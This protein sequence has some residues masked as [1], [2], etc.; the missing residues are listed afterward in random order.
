MIVVDTN[1]VAYLLIEG[2]RTEQARTVWAHDAEWIVPSLWRS[3]ML[4]VLATAVRASVLTFDEAELVRERAWD[5]F[6]ARE[7]NPGAP[8]VLRRAVE[9]GISAYDAQF[10]VVAEELDLLLVTGD[11][12]L[13]AAA[14]ARGRRLDEM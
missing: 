8:T 3:E 9:L 2:E 1:V 12:R 11:R 10:V 14:G 4:N 13:A 5:L 6:V 7:R